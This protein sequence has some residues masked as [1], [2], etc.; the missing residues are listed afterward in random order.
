MKILHVVAGDLSGGAARGA[1]WLHLA[2]RK[3]GIESSLLTDSRTTYNDPFIYSFGS[4]ALNYFVNRVFNKLGNFPIRLYPKRKRRI[5]ST[6][7][8]GFNIV[9]TKLYNECDVVHLHW[10][11][12][13]ISIKE[14][15]EISKPIVWTLRDMWPFTGGCH[16]AMECVNYITGCGRCPQLGSSSFNDLSRCIILRK[17]HHFPKSMIVVGISN[18][19]SECAKASAAFKN[20]RIITINNNININEFRPKNKTEARNELRLD[21]FKKYILIGAQN[22]QDFYK[23]F[24]LI[25]T[26]LQNLNSGNY[27]LLVFGNIDARIISA[28]GL[29]VQNFGFLR[30]N[31]SLSRL[32]SAADAFVAPSRM[33]AFGKTLVESMACGTPVVCFDST[34]PKDIV[35]HKVNGYKAAPFDP[36][37]LA[38]GVEWILSQDEAT[39]AALSASAEKRARTVFDSEI[40]AQ[41]YKK[42][43]QTILI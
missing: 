7:L 16:Y 2:Q 19:I 20:Q 37:D 38:K 29:P 40:I 35:E 23:G 31:K 4:S 3:I 11:N 9:A 15:G 13:L 1:Y 5:F 32:Y 8:S 41:Q 14:I 36:V 22:S 28:T 39:Y 34:G 43:Y 17:Q 18:W 12:G 6:G 30:D 26:C 33:E 42:L 21:L 10:V 25:L 27:N 24:D